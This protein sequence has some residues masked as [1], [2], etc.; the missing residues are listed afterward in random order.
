MSP[1]DEPAAGFAAARA[2]AGGGNGGQPGNGGGDLSLTAKKTKRRGA[3]N[4]MSLMEE[5]NAAARKSLELRRGACQTVKSGSG[6][7]HALLH[8]VY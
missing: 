4:Q 3:G 8:L 1:G 5:K 2:G 7:L 6:T